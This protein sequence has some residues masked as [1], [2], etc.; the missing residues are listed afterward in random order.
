MAFAG[1]TLETSF[2]RFVPSMATFSEW[3]ALSRPFGCWEPTSMVR[4]RAR[5][6][7]MTHGLGGGPKP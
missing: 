2:A 5:G 3:R 1:G 6:K 4:A 7:R